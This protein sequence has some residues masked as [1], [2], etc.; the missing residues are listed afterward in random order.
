MVGALYNGLQ[1]GEIKNLPLGKNLRDGFNP[2]SVRST[3]SR[4]LPIPGKSPESK[5]FPATLSGEQPLFCVSLR[6]C[7]SACYFS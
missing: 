7:V 2:D 6:L 4:H 1:P 5:G 3:D